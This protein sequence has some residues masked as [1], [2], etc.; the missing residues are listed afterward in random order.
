MIK[1]QLTQFKRM[2]LPMAARGN[3]VYVLSIAECIKYAQDNPNE[4][5]FVIAKHPQDA[6][7]IIES[8]R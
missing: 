8:G 2:A 4:T 7:Q 3:T 6:L 5:L 1:L